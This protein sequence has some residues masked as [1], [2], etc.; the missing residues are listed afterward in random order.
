VQACLARLCTDS[1]FLRVFRLDPDG[2]LDDYFLTDEERHAMSEI[3][4]AGLANF[5]RSVRAKRLQV[6]EAAYPAL[7][8]LEHQALRVYCDRYLDLYP[9]RPYETWG[10]DIVA[11]GGFM[12]ETLSDG[13]QL[14]PY[15]A[16]LVRFVRAVQQLRFG[17]PADDGPAERASRPVGLD[18][19]PV[20]CDGVA[21]ERFTFN[22]SEIDDALRNEREPTPRRRPEYVVYARRPS[23]VAPRVMRVSESTAELIELCDGTRPL[24]EAIARTGTAADSPDVEQARRVVDRL[25]ADGTLE[26][27]NDERVSARP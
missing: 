8:A 5:A 3:D 26:L 18:D 12:A 22:V 11:F 7:F 17:E 27:R 19:R 9:R 16:E 4:V 21:V 14:P 1:A 24:H 20:R 15:A 25:I 2:A 10:A 6:L 23:S 13:G